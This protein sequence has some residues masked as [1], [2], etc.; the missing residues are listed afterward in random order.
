VRSDGSPD[1]YA[2]LV[3]RWVVCA[4]KLLCRQQSLDG[5]GRWVGRDA[6]GAGQSLSMGTASTMA[7]LALFDVTRRLQPKMALVKRILVQV[8]HTRFR[9]IPAKNSI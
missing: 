2:V 9:T 4:L 5:S 1:N 8:S 3:K 6:L 7:E